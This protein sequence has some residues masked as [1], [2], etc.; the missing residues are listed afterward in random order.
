MICCNDAEK[1]SNIE[2]EIYSLLVIFSKNGLGIPGLLNGIYSSIKT[3]S[4]EMSPSVGC[5]IL[6]ANPELILYSGIKL[7]EDEADLVILVND[8]EYIYH[9]NSFLLR[10]KCLSIMLCRFD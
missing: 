5:D 3:V 4:N 10:M 9:F 6:L 7:L 2:E 1:F 8:W